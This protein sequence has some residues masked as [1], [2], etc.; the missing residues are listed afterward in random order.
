ML[1]A[2]WVGLP[3]PPCSLTRVPRS[4]PGAAPPALPAS[5]HLPRQDEQPPG[6][7][8]WQR[9]QRGVTPSLEPQ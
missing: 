6:A 5:R 9:W 4:R 1:R 7:R 3:W 8:G 2:A